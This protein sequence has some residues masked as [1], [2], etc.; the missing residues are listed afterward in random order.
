LL[1]IPQ[2]LFPSLVTRPWYCLSGWFSISDIIYRELSIS[3]GISTILNLVHIY[4]V[5][6]RCETT[7][8]TN[9]EGFHESVSLWCILR[10]RQAQG[11]GESQ[12]YL[13]RGVCCTAS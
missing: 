2:T 3:V 10:I 1:R 5:F 7:G 9:E 12:H 4:L 8:S 13:D 6:Y 11:A